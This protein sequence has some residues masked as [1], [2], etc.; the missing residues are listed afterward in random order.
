MNGVNAVWHILG[1][2]KSVFIAHKVVLFGILCICIRTGGFQ[3]NLKFSAYFGRFNLC[4]AVVGML[5]DRN[6][7]LYYVLCDS[8]RNEITFNCVFFRLSAYRMNSRIKQISF[9][10]RNLLNRIISA[11]ILL[12]LEISVFIGRIGIHELAVLVQSVNCS[13]KRSVALC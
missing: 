12:C 1:L 8:H 11:D 2:C 6:I 7:S 5:D 9:G 13:R 10:G 4:A 3:I